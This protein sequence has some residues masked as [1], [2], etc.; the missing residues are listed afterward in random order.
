[1]FFV[2]LLY[3]KQKMIGRISIE[4][5]DFRMHSKEVR[6]ARLRSQEQYDELLEEPYISEARDEIRTR[7]M[8]FLQEL[9]DGDT[10][11]LSRIRLMN[12]LNHCG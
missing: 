10:K 9:I 4:E 3:R 6:R 2:F 8:G 12:K 5:H 7:I 1:M 11:E